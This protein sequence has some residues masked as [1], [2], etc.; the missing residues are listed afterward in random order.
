MN[1]QYFN[2]FAFLL[3]LFLLENCNLISD[4]CS[5][6]QHPKDELTTLV[7]LDSI[8]NNLISVSTN[9]KGIEFENLTELEP[10]E[11]DNSFNDKLALFLGRNDSAEINTNHSKIFELG[12][13]D[14]NGELNLDTIKL[15][16]NYVES[17]NCPFIEYGNLQITY[18]GSMVFNKEYT[19]RIEIRRP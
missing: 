3:I 12:L 11:L 6:V 17:S 16:Y 14:S 4:D 19:H 8:G 13:Y 5:S 7:I 15:D 1:K 9:T 18:N 10:V 2:L